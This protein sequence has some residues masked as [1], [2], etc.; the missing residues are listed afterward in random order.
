MTRS[1]WASSVASIGLALCS[2]VGCRR[3]A[4]LQPARESSVPWF[5]EMSARAGVDFTYNSGHTDRHNLPEIMGGGA[6]L[7]DMDNDGFLDLYLVQ[8]G[9]L[10]T[11][12]SRGGN[13]LYRLH[14]VERNAEILGEVIE[15]A[16]RD[17]GER[18]AAVCDGGCGGA[19]S[20]VTAGRHDQR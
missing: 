15:R 10:L 4:G 13:R 8:G 11:E 18:R 7:F 1:R 5:E 16:E 3:E 14:G 17:D 2:F 20:S 6:A 9:T 19:Y 12:S